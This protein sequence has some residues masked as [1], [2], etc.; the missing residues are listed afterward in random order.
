MYKEVDVHCRPLL[1]DRIQLSVIPSYSYLVDNIICSD[2]KQ[3]IISSRKEKGFNS[4]RFNNDNKLYYMVIIPNFEDMPYV[5]DIRVSA[6]V[7]FT[8]SFK[9]NFIRLLRS[10]INNFDNF[11]YDYDILLDENNYLNYE[12]WPYWDNNKVYDLI[13]ELELICIGI[14]DRS[15]KNLIQ[16]H[17]LI[18]EKVTVSQIETNVDYYVGKNNSYY[19]MDK[20]S[21]FIGSD[22][23]KDFRDNIREI[24]VNCRLPEYN[25]DYNPTK[26]NKNES[27][28]IQFQINDGVFL[29]IYRKDRDH[30]RAELTFSKDI[31]EKKFK[32]KNKV[33]GKTKIS[34][35]RDIKRILNPV[36]EFSKRYFKKLDLE[37]L[38]AGIMLNKFNLKV[39]NQLKLLY[40]FF[41][42]SDSRM[43]PI[44]NNVLNGL[45]V[46]DPKSI[47]FLQ[48]NRKYGKNFVRSYDIYGNWFY[49][50]DPIESKRKRMDMINNRFAKPKVNEV[51]M[52]DIPQEVLWK[53]DKMIVIKK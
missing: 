15:L 10:R 41:D 27:F 21:N 2:Y 53:G 8:V 44:I 26:L 51:L 29:K 9:L 38:F 13:N 19:L 36:C 11:R 6:F 7:P 40:D 45:P 34:K 12:N 18:Y 37:N 28:S 42:I 47:K 39:V 3:L 49:H 32:V 5:S 17:N 48:N 33:N 52:S 22:L 1:M 20:I 50:Y 14:A 43:L 31:L 35:S 25:N 4:K 30:I 16:D 23:G 24:G 46:R